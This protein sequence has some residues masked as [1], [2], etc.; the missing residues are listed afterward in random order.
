MNSFCLPETLHGVNFTCFKKAGNSNFFSRII[1]LPSAFRNMKDFHELFKNALSA[2]ERALSLPQRRF[3]TL[4]IIKSSKHLINRCK[5]YL[6]H[7]LVVIGVTKKCTQDEAR[8]Q[9]LKL[10][11]QQRKPNVTCALR[12]WRLI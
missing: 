9:E 7:I 6:K 8:H 11:Q 5:I 10:L 1:V 12:D 2:F 3:L 4:S